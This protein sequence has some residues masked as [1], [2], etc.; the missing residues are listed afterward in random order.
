V[1]G[2][3][4]EQVL[5]ED[6]RAIERYSAPI[7]GGDGSSFGRVWFFQDVTERRRLEKEILEAG[8]RER[9]KIGQDLHDDLCQQLTGIACLARVLRQRLAARSAEEAGDAATILHLVQQAATC[10]RNLSKGL[11]PVTLE[12]DGLASALQDLCSRVESA[13]GVPCR[14]RGD[15]SALASADATV[16]THL[17][18]IAQEAL[19]NA[20]KHGNAHSISVDLISAGERLILAVED[21]GVG[22]PEVLAG[23]GLGLHTMDHRARIIGA[24]LSVER[25]T[26]GGTT[27]TCSLRNAAS[28]A[29]TDGNL[30]R[31]R[32]VELG[33]VNV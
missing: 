3:G 31:A 32:D 10:A 18:R 25:G 17:Y 20:I 28:A 9:Q 13:C 2:D 14:F 27:V 12:A 23:D 4:C 6:G 22:I 15:S 26:A 33:T 1:I 19:N 8:E 5:L 16:P 21:D 29:R 30:P 7:V 24:S 11:Q